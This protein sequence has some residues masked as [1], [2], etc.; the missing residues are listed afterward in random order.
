MRGLVPS[1]IELHRRMHVNTK[2][3]DFV[4]NALARD[5]GYKWL[6]PQ[7]DPGT[8]PLLLPVP[9]GTMGTEIDDYCL[10]TCIDGITSLLFLKFL[11][12]C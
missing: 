3:P 8:V 2:I 5:C 7:G 12:T 4:L 11:Y 6:R 9:S 10:F 1:Q